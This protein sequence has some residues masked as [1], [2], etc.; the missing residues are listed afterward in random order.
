MEYWSNENRF[1]TFA[2]PTL[3]YSNTP[4][5]GLNNEKIVRVSENEN[6]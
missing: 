6:S 3:Q 5:K 4:K 1:Q 2:V